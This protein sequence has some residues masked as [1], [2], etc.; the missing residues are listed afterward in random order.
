MKP[1]AQRWSHAIVFLSA[2]PLS[3]EVALKSMGV[4]IRAEDLWWHLGMGRVIAVEHAVPRSDAFSYTRNGLPYF[5][6]PWLAQLAMYAVHANC[7]LAGLLACDFVIMIAAEALAVLAAMR[8]GAGFGV[9]C[10][11]QLAVGPIAW[12]GWPMR[13]QAFAVPIFAAFV[14]VLSAY[15]KGR[16]APLWL[17]PL[18]MVAWANL[19]GSFPLGLALVLLTL[20]A[21]WIDDRVVLRPL[22]WTA[23]ACTAAPIVNPRGPALFGYVH[24]LL[25]SSTV[26][27][28]AREWQPLSLADGEGRYVAL[29]LAGALVLTVLRR[30]RLGDWLMVAPFALLEISAVRNGIWLSLVLGPIAAAWL[31]RSPEAVA[32]RLPRY[33]LAAAALAVGV[34]VTTPW[35]KTRIVPAPYGALAWHQRTPIAA[36]DWMAHTARAPRRLFHGMG[37]GSYLIWAQPNQRVFIDPRIEF[38]PREQWN[39]TLALSA[40][41]RVS[42]ITARYGFDAWLLD[43]HEQ[44]PLI[45]ALRGDRKLRLSYE[46]ADSA[47][48]EPR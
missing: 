41:D 11:V 16:S 24:G 48:F 29:I 13:P 38:Y 43:Q 27:A 32:R 1:Q 37:A 12:R 35:W 26:R 47:Y 34:L 8:R 17:L 2:L 28:I 25:D 31:G 33:A 22:V 45:A 39:D 7:G 20:G 14:Y 6:Q 5:D 30:A 15:R 4:P 18:L 44:A 21:V 10:L 3:V 19:H 36:V 46:D 40:A 9:A 42:E 23:L